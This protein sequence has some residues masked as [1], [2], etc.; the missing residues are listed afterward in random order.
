MA[1]WNLFLT[2]VSAEVAAA[3]GRA[4]PSKNF[5]PGVQEAASCEPSA[6][7]MADAL[8]G[9]EG[10]AVGAIRAVS[11]G[12]GSRRRHS[13]GLGQRLRR[14]CMSL[15]GQHGSADLATRS[16]GLGCEA[17]EARQPAILFSLALARILAWLLHS[18][19]IGNT[20]TAANNERAGRVRGGGGLAAHNFQETIAAWCFNKN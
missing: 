9:A 10:P 13:L 19:Q 14:R 20:G 7:G 17:L 6:L 2:D 18:S 12:N 15:I 5:I 8:E 11:G 4:K 3:S 16:S 1:P